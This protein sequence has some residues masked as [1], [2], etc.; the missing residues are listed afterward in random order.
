M[1]EHRAAADVLRTI[2]VPTYDDRLW[3]GQCLCMASD[4]DG[5]RTVLESCLSER[6]TPDACYWLAMTLAKGKQRGRDLNE[7]RDQVCSLLSKSRQLG[8]RVPFVYSWLADLIGEQG[9][10]ANGE[11][12]S[13][14]RDGLAAAPNERSI[15]QSLAKR[16]ARSTG[17][18]QEALDLLAPLLQDAVP[19]VEALWIAKEIH[20]WRGD[21]QAE[22]DCINRAMRY[23]PDPQESFGLRLLRGDLLMR[24]GRVDEAI[25]DFRHEVSKA[26]PAAKCLASL[27]L[28][29]ISGRQD[30][31]LHAF[32][33]A[34]NAV[35]SWLSSGRGLLA[36][37]R[38]I[39]LDGMGG[40]IWIDP[41]FYV[42]EVAELLEPHVNGED[43]TT[44]V[45]LL[46]YWSADSQ[47]SVEGRLKVA[48][49]LPP[50]RFPVMNH[51]WSLIAA[52]D[53]D[54]MRALSHYITYVEQFG[55]MPEVHEVYRWHF[56]DDRD[57]T[58]ERCFKDA[59]V[60]ER[61]HEKLVGFA[62]RHSQNRSILEWA[63]LPLY[64]KIWHRIL[65]S[66]K[67]WQR[68]YEVA[69]FLH[70]AFGEDRLALFDHAFAARAL[71][72]KDEAE[73]AYRKLVALH[74]KYGPALHNLSI[75]VESRSFDE[76]LDLQ[77]RAIEFN[78]QCE[79][80]K[81]RSAALEEE[82]KRRRVAAEQ[83]AE[84]RRIAMERQEDF[85]KT[86]RERW[87]QL[88]YF[89]RKLLGALTIIKNGF[90]NWAHLAQLTGIEAR[91][92]Q[93]HWRKLVDD[94]FII[95]SDGHY[96]V[97]KYV[98]D[99]VTQERSHAVATTIVRADP[100]IFYKPIFNSK[101]EYEVYKVLLE[102]FPNHL[103]FPNM[104]LMTIFQFD[105]MK[106]TLDS[107]DFEYYMR[108]QVDFC[109]T[110]TANYLPLIAFEVDSDYH[111]QEKQVTRDE[112]KNRIFQKG[113]IPLIRLRPHGRPSESGLRHDIV[114]VIQR[115]GKELR[116]SGQKAEGLVRLTL[117][118][119]FEHFGGKDH[120]DG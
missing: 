75:L 54:I 95:E 72:K 20:E 31:M 117:E 120:A 46:Q 41:P 28:A 22:L 74:P 33:H 82:A 118:I 19:S 87:P 11:V 14:L 65:F 47:C 18:E 102:L 115:L 63:V 110:S 3:V 43:D 78:P 104:S 12:E 26:H 45:R 25:Q 113:G 86:A 56:F 94:G 64:H 27:A 53:G 73:E 98:L 1:D 92:L 15:R 101:K 100:S 61:V 69:A 80:T 83:E 37:A 66:G 49:T 85:L 39:R 108:S 16:I 90:D 23:M 21:W 77:R 6:E 62:V 67:M 60:A 109:V 48:R 13:I 116:E 70:L 5:A 50:K 114:G 55:S 24:H 68:M 88:D 38:P 107:S 112:R 2:T 44:T 9:S 93:G 71:E 10:A 111:D 7:S 42:T 76:A 99:L 59:S 40:R 103:V 34:R 51:D 81:K 29:Y 52:R 57:F 30:K 89:K 35:D 79:T 4:W 105:R 17:R 97:N 119:D 58:W 32:T 96:E 36:Q 8:S 106:E 84:R 91:Y